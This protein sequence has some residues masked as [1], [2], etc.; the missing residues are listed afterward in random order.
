MHTGRVRIVFRPRLSCQE[1]LVARH[2]QIKAKQKEIGPA[3]SPL[4]FKKRK[5]ATKFPCDQIGTIK[6]CS[7][8]QNR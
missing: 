7:E 8:K 5:A 6:S 1:R 3:F 4:I 2:M